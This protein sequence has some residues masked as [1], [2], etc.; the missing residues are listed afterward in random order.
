MTT[1]AGRDQKETAEL[2]GEIDAIVA[3]VKGAILELEKD[4]PSQGPRLTL[5]AADLKLNI[6]VTK[7]VGGDFKF[8][9]FG[10]D[11]GGGVDLTKVDTQTITLSLTPD[12]SAAMAFGV[13]DVQTRLVNAMRA[14]R[15]S[16]ARAAISEPRFSLDDAT[17]ELNFEVDKD[18]KISFIVTGEGKKTNAQT[19]TLT[20]G[21]S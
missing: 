10:H 3:Q 21:S 5:K 1:D 15:D 19:I 13:E 7:D 6:A 12:A 9:L 18:G 8:K 16:V 11:F 4:A 20:L 14:I 17:V 2:A